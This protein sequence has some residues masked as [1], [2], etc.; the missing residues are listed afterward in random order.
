MVQFLV[1]FAVPS[2]LDATQPGVQLGQ[3]A[4]MEARPQQPRHGLAVPA[5]GLWT[6]VARLIRP[7]QAPVLLELPDQEAGD[8]G[9]AELKDEK[10]QAGRDGFHRTEQDG[11][12]R[13]HEERKNQLVRHR[14]DRKMLDRIELRFGQ[15]V[16]AE[17]HDVGDEE[18]H[19]PQRRLDHQPPS[20]VA[21]AEAQP[22]IDGVEQ[23]LH[24][25]EQPAEEGQDQADQTGDHVPR[26]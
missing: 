6:Q 7:I 5:R 21:A 24:T 11:R 22:F 15:Q 20:A 4:R 19:E 14:H 12:Q 1:P 2:R 10:E 3:R 25:V 23:P 8:A 16:D 17:A 13:R 9:K 18:P 26:K